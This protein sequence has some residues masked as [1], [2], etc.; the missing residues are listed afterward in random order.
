M[1]PSSPLENVRIVLSH[2]SH[3][4]NIGATARA[5][6]TMGLT[7]LYLIN[8]K[9]FPDKEAEIRAVNARD[10][11]NRIT[12]CT[13]LDQ[14]LDNTVLAAAMTARPRG[15]SHAMFNS[16]QGAQELLNYAQKHPVALVFGAETS[17][18]TTAEVNK[19]QIIVHIPTNP[20]YS[21]LN[22]AS[23][24]QVMAYELRMA[25]LGIE[26]PPQAPGTPASFN[27]IELFYHHLEQAMITS[28]FLDPE[29]PRRLM[30]RI[31]RLYAR[32]RLE[33]EEVSILRGIL[34][35][36]EKKI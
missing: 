23:A 3:P 21:S 5:M 10:I 9:Q 7:S 6:K 29:K 31:R 16:R 26:P 20:D 32:A 19:C 33:K 8:P 11:L 13:H 18:L 4:G 2:T 30:Q 1:N 25:L 22:L 35:A 24:V 17:G 27:E 28:D 36:L 15:L 12:I 14:A 34:S